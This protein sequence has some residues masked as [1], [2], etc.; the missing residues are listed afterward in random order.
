MIIV[1][2]VGLAAAAVVAI[3]IRK[4]YEIR[5]DN[6][7]ISRGEKPKYNNPPVIEVIDWTRRK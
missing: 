2:S 4:W 5:S 6:E 3:A 1:V 7:R